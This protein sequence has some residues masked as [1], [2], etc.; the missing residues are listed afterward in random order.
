VGSAVS[1]SDN[2]ALALRNRV[3]RCQPRVWEVGLNLSQHC[4]H[5]ISPYLSAMILAV[6]CEAACCRLAYQSECGDQYSANGA[7]LFRVPERR[8]I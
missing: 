6:L 5:A 2:D 7:A 4:P 8:L 3:Q 1:A